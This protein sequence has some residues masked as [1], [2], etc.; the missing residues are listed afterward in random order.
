MD[1]KRVERIERNKYKRKI[2]R[3]RKFARLRR[4]LLYTGVK[5]N[6]RLVI[7]LNEDERN[8]IDKVE[9]QEGIEIKFI[10]RQWIENL[11]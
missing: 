4:N 9:N 10:I 5:R 11:K 2:K 1:I 7:W 3:Y 6:K 8:L